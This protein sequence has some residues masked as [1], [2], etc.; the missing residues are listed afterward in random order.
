MKI[1][2]VGRPNV[3]K[4]TLFNRLTRRR[5]AIVNDMPGVTRDRRYGAADLF[6]ENF[7]IIDTPGMEDP[8]DTPL[9]KG[10]WEQSLRAIHESDVIIFVVDGRVGIVPADTAIARQL[11]K[12][13]KP[14][15]LV[16][17]KC[18]GHQHIQAMSEAY[19]LGVGEPIFISA[20]HGEGFSDFY[21]TL[22]HHLPPLDEPETTLLPV[23]HE[24]GDREEKEGGVDT[25]LRLAIVGRPNAGKSTLINKFLR[26]ERLLTGEQPGITRDAIEIPWVY[27][28]R[29]MM[30][31]DT[32]G[33]RKRAKVTD[34]LERLSVQDSLRAVQY[35]HVV[36]LTV[37]ADSPLDKQDMMIARHI[38]DEGR[39]LVV[40]INKWDLVTNT[41][42]VMSLI[43]RRLDDGLAYVRGVPVVP[44]S[45]KTGFHFKQLMEQVFLIYAQW[46]RRIPTAALNRWLDEATALHPPPMI[47]RRALKMKYATQ[48]K[49]RPPTFALF[50]N[51]S[52]DVP[53]TYL[54]YLTNSLRTAFDLPG[55]PIRIVIRASKNPYQP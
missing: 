36:V 23:V 14:C 19:R 21:D 39:C 50:A 35:A 20:E 22:A 51:R 45:A 17:N 4:S 29:Q 34:T 33:M 43:D 2:L 5:S 18:E 47:S 27:D 24:E 1:A 6:G 52:D 44:I 40:A 16:V 9:K 30:L 41:K 49:S 53:E 37:D 46:Q 42:A 15:F 3:G 55:V 11:R 8:A 32:A 31:I 25:P 12:L 13:G 54:R 48:I 10:M 7:E 38:I 26:E 28:G